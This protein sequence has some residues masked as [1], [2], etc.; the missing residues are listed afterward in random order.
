[1]NPEEKKLEIENEVLNSYEEL[2]STLQSNHTPEILYHYTSFDSL[3][4]M[5]KNSSIWMSHYLYLNDPTE[6]VHVLE[7]LFNEII[8]EDTVHDSAFW[9]DIKVIILEKILYQPLLPVGMFSLSKSRDSLDQWR[10]Y[11][12]QGRGVCVGID[13][14]M[15][16]NSDTFAN[17]PAFYGGPLRVLYNEVQQNEIYKKIAKK[18]AHTISKH[19]DIISI[20]IRK[21]FPILQISQIVYLLGISLK[22]SHWLSEEEYR[23]FA[24]AKHFDFN[25]RPSEHGLS[26]YFELKFK[27]N[28][29]PVKEIII[30]SKCNF[31]LQQHSLEIMTKGSKI[32]IDKSNIKWR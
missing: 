12:N 4:S 24:M 30:G 15:L 17:P 10:G 7:P 31:M 29:L 14:S 3:N 11:G 16:S 1:M 5:F 25:V 23:F 22:S 20:D 13:S 32:A 27:P 21:Y 9:S 18:I 2:H 19:Q 28:L 8:K 6:V 26:P